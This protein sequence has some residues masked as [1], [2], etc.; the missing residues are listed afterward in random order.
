VSL[1]LDAYAERIGY[2]G[3]RE[4]TLDVLRELHRLH[5]AAIPFENLTTLLG[6]TPELDLA[7]L[8]EKLVRAGRGGYCFEQNRLFASVL[9]ALGFE[10]STLAARVLWERGPGTISA[11]THMLLAVRLDGS[12]YIADVGFGALTLTAPLLLE[13]GLEQAT[14]HERFRLVRRSG[15]FVVEAELGGAADWRPL[16]WFDLSE[17]LEI[18]FTVLNHFVATHPASP[19]PVVLM[20]ARA[21]PGRRLTLSNA[22]YAA[23]QYGSEAEHRAI[24]G[25][26]GLR[27]VL[28]RDFGI[29]LPADP[30]IEAVLEKAARGAPVE[31]ER[32]ERS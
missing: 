1:D 9:E 7:S 31:A 30:G 3:P 11:R 20:A 10:V 13:P 16:Y 29:V 25:A 14:P 2:A 24:D 28:S 19:F 18:D 8:E 6:R 17:F 23:R 26:S 15:G 4:P 32:R 5:P 21:L 27:D 22:R 12:T